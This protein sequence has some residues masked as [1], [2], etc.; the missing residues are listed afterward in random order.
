MG[1][2]TAAGSS[3]G[4]SASLPAT[5]DASGYAALTFIEIGQVEKLGTFGAAFAKVEYQPLKGAKQKYKGSADY[6][7]LQ[8]SIAIDDADAGQT[9]MLVAADDETQKLYSFRVTLQDGAKRYFRGRVFGSPETADGADTMLLATPTVEI[10]T[11][12]VRVDAGVTPAPSPT[13]SQP[14]ITPAS[15]AVGTTFTAVD[16][17]VTNGTLTGRRWLLGTTAIGTGTTVTPNAAGSLTLEN[18]AVGTNGAS[19]TSTSTAVT[20]SAATPTPTPTPTPT[21]FAASHRV[22]PLADSQAAGVGTGTGS[23]GMIGA[24][25]L[26]WPSV[27]SAQLVSAGYLSTAN[28]IAE[29]ANTGDTI[30]LYDSRISPG[31]FNDVGSGNNLGGYP[32]IYGSGTTPF[33]AS[34]N[35][36]DTFEVFTTRTSAGA[37][38][39]SMSID[40]GAA[41]TVDSNGA[42]AHVKTTLTAAKGNHTVSIARATGTPFI[43]TVIGYDSTAKDARILNMAA[44]G[45]TTNSFL[46]A[47]TPFRVFNAVRDILG[48]GDLSLISLGGNDRR[49]GG[50]LNTVPT[51]QANLRSIISNVLSAGASCALVVQMPTATS[52]DGSFTH[53]QM[54]AAMEAVAAEFGILCW[55]P[56]VVLGTWEAGNAAGITFDTLHWKAPASQTYAT[57]LQPR[58][59]S[60]LL[61]IEQS[62]VATTAPVVSGNTAVGSVLTASPGTFSNSPTSRTYQWQRNGVPISGATG[63]TYTTVT[64]D[65]GAA[66]RIAETGLN[67]S[68]TS[69]NGVN[70]RVSNSITVNAAAG[71]SLASDDFTMAD[72]AL[73]AGRT[74]STGGAWSTTGVWQAFANRVWGQGFAFLPA[75]GQPASGNVSVS[76]Q[77]TFKSSI[78]NFILLRYTD[79]SNYIFAGFRASQGGWCINKNVGGVTTVV[80]SVAAYTPAA[81]DVKVVRADANGQT[82]TLYVDGTQVA[83][84]TVTEAA[85]QAASTIGLY[86]AATGSDT[87]GVHFDNYSAA[88]L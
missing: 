54:A 23:T 62:P 43:Q 78:A 7:A 33:T 64:A 31:S 66:I 85:L 73:L 38:T 74:A 27:L 59:A 56:D 46:T 14:S 45:W 13:L 82:I 35:A 30:N 36:I 52:Q 68:A 41:T 29:A 26:S 69:A 65:S 71:T 10:C 79:A 88:A 55:R 34:F 58:V 1:S 39:L 32:H 48:P 8:P 53:A 77:F 75:P 4:I 51:Y 42:A 15:G 40:G 47:D 3:L 67:A 87:T 80:G 63:M 19:I 21:A 22:V 72:A 83:T 50:I 20:V 11:R 84:G 61:A 5:H 49:T 2:Q 81:G 12:V 76:T 18:S 44:R 9:L 70:T 16:G 57:Y 25:P 86:A 28:S 37:G 60:L 24:R 6:G 17:T